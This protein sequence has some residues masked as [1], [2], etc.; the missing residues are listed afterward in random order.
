[1][2]KS[3]TP[4]HI[5]IYMKAQERGLLSLK[6]GTDLGNFEG[7]AYGNASLRNT[8]GG[9][10]SFNLNISRGTRTRSAYQ[11][12]FDC[13]ILSDPDKQLSIDCLAS[14]TLKPW[15]SHEEVNKG[16]GASYSWVSKNGARHKVG[17][18]GVWRQVTG[19]SSEASPTIRH[20]AGDSAKSSITHTWVLDRLD[21]SLMPTH[22][23]SVKCISE[24]A[25]WGPLQGDVA[26]CKSEVESTFAF[27][28]QTP[29][30][31]GSSGVSFT[32]GLRA[33]LLYP[34][35]LGVGGEARPSRINDRFQLGGPTDVR[36]F[37]LSGLGPR[38]GYDSVGGDIYAAASANL[39]F[40]VP[41]IGKL[42]PLRFQIFANA[43][44]LLALSEESVKVDKGKI[45]SQRNFLATFAKLGDGLPSLAAGVGFVYAHPI[46]RFELNFCLP[47]IL[48][49]GEEGRKGIQLGVG[50]NFL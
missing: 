4:T 6:T 41:R 32:S 18:R 46:A 25:G 9:A 26:F 17:Y 34:L 31:K 50:I 38:D 48:R 44:R 23:F 1:M 2:D 36:G 47:L 42:K 13:P 5:D 35:P 14:S 11:A 43:G 39:L 24:I 15:A 3:L 30:S 7:S 49:K 12:T 10:E 29:G 16:G 45:N 20:E 28:I 22:G 40:P 37:K 33:G 21:N 27:P 19:L 8:F